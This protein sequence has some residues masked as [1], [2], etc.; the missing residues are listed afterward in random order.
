MLTTIIGLSQWF[1]VY[2]W[3]YKNF[4]D[5]FFLNSRACD[6]H[7]KT[8]KLILLELATITQ[9]L[10]YSFCGSLQ[11]SHKI[12]YTHFVGAYN[13]HTKSFILIL[14]ELTTITQKLL[15]SFCGSLQPSHKNFYTHFAGAYNHHTKTFILIL[16]ELTTITQKLLYSFCSIHMCLWPLQDLF[17]IRRKKTVMYILTYFSIWK[18]ENWR[19]IVWWRRRE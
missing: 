13:H 4:E 5:C 8:L 10:L 7:T 2:W 12:F 16:R 1:I 11:P 14:L 19:Y 17:C 6:H 9:K 3:W 18:Y 15:Y